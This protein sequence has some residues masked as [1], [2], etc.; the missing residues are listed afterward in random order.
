MQ[1]H[2]LSIRQSRRSGRRSKCRYIRLSNK[3]AYFLAS[4]ALHGF[5]GTTQKLP[6]SSISQRIP[7]I[8]G[9]Q[10][11]PRWRSATSASAQKRDLENRLLSVAESFLHSTLGRR[12]VVAPYRYVGRFTSTIRHTGRSFGVTTRG[13]GCWFASRVSSPASA[14]SGDAAIERRRAG[15]EPAENSQKGT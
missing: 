3:R 14:N 1:R 12:G 10:S 15:N 11:T 2:R 9:K 4:M 7:G 13:C 8:M 6:V 5:R